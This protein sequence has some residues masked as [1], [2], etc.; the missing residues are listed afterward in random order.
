MRSIILILLAAVL[1]A[2]AA[3]ASGGGAHLDHAAVDIGNRS[4]LQRGAKYFF[5]YCVSCHSA[6]FS[7]YNRIATDLGLSDLQV[8]DNFIFTDSTIRDHMTVAMRPKDAKEW[9]GTAPPDLTLSARAKGADWLYTYLRSFYLDDTRPF[10]VNNLVLVNA[11]MPHVLWELQGLQKRAHKEAEAHAEGGHGDE[12]GHGGGAPVLEL[13]RPG[14][15][16]PDQYDRAVLDLVNFMVYLSEPAQVV[17]KQIGVWVLSF[18]LLLFVVTY[19]LKKEY[20]K[21]IH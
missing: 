15:M 13:V 21:D 6:N 5:N 19:L 4:S 18:L 10:G 2:G 8:E 14:T 3:V 20:W 9:F 1:P 17:R 12:Q 11:A 7:R 16:S